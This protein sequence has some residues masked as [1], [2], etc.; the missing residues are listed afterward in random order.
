M[1]TL[2]M[3]LV[4]NTKGCQGHLLGLLAKRHDGLLEVPRFLEVLRHQIF[5]L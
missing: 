5:I 1:T 2:P 3:Q 4:S